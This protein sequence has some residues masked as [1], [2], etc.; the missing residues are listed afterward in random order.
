[1]RFSVF[2]SVA[3]AL[4]AFAGPQTHRLEKRGQ[5]HACEDTGLKIPLRTE[6]GI[7]LVGF[8]KPVSQQTCLDF[9]EG[10]APYW[11]YTDPTQTVA[12]EVKT[13][14]IAP[15]ETKCEHIVEIQ[16]LK[17]VLES[18]GGPCSQIPAKQGR[19]PEIEK[20]FRLKF[21]QITDIINNRPNIVFA[22]KALEG[23]KGDLVNKWQNGKTYTDKSK[24]NLLM[25]VNDFLSRTSAQSLG[26][27]AEL[28]VR[29]A[30]LFPG[31]KLHVRD[32]WS[33]V[34]SFAA[35][36]HKGL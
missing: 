8:S 5:T 20:E 26:V 33:G 15:D 25:A 23:Q 4:G 24:K 19:T 16:L 13:R 36:A 22:D 17:Q 14:V 10:E 6:P 34:L 9:N 35:T 18:P 27:A 2:V 1:M 32:L 31:T 30:Q 21:K 3:F 12:K 11:T 29:I 7:P 28:D